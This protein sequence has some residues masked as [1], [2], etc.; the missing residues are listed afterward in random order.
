MNQTSA[1]EYFRLANEFFGKAL[2]LGYADLEKYFWYHTIDLGNDSAAW[3]VPN[4]RCFEQVLKKLGFKD[5][6]VVGKHSGFMRPAGISYER[7]II[8]A[9]RE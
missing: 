9:K 4:G 3:W 7:S 1:D 8:H 5:V 6:A 2:E